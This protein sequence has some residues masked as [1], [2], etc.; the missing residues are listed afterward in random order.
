MSEKERVNVLREIAES[1]SNLEGVSQT[2]KLIEKALKQKCSVTDIIE[3]GLKKGLDEV[4]SKY[5]RGEY[6]LAELL[7][8]GEIM[9]GL[10][11]I[12]K[13]HIKHE[14][15]GEKATIVL[16][17]V[18]GDMHDIGKNIF[19][20]MAR[21][22]G[23]EIRDLGVDVDPKRFVEEVKE[24]DAEIVGM[25]TLL[26]STLPEVKTVLDELKNAGLRGKVRVIIGGNAVTKEFAEEVGADAAALDA[27][28]GVEICRRW[29]GA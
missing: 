18:K 4:G 8:A 5:E 15:M 26:T 21:F 10:L 12:L 9:S 20:M 24:T 16:G 19:G 25:S 29:I 7:Y 17:T 23:F 14:G 22:S 6:F 3:G 13:S 1:I 27:V 28:E 2:R 11:D